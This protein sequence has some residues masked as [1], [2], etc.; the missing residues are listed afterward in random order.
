MPDPN[1]NLVPSEIEKLKV[2]HKFKMEN[3]YKQKKLLSAEIAKWA[4]E[5][6]IS[7]LAME[8]SKFVVIDNWDIKTCQEQILVQVECYYIM[9]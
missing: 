8:A 6:D 5:W 1:L 7:E 9:A 3:Q 2:L 4:F